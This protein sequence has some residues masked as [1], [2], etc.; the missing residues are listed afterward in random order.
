MAIIKEMHFEISSHIENLASAGLSGS[1]VE[2]TE[3]SP[4]GFFK[5]S[6]DA[7]IISYTEESEGGRIFTDISVSGGEV[8]LKR[9][10]AVVSDM[11]FAEG[12]VHKSE[13]S[14]PPYT[15]DTV[16][17]TKKVRNNLTRAGG[18]LDLYYE[19]NI[20][21]QDKKVRMKIEVAPGKQE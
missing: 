17:T 11:H 2:K 4:D 16:I 3:I 1:D 13:Y 7:Y 12:E 21:G 14:V 10:G 19:M 6:D 18:R 9:R 20:G 15:F 5:I 8:D